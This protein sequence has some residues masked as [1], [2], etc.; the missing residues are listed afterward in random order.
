MKRRAFVTTLFSSA[1]LIGAGNKLTTLN[2]S[3]KSPAAVRFRF[4]VASDGHYGQPDTTFDEYHDEMMNWLNLEH[5]KKPLAFTMFNGDLIHDEP[6]LLPRVKTKYDQ[7]SMPYYTSH[8]NHDRVDESVWRNTWST[9]FNYSF[10]KDDLAFV[11]LNTA[12]I[13]GKYICPDVRWAKKELRKYRD[14]KAIFVFMHISPVR[15][16]ENGLNCSSLTSL[17]AK[18]KNLKAIFHGH[19]HD[20]DAM[21]PNRGKPHFFDSH[22]GG[23]WGTDYRGYRVVEVLDNGDILTYQINPASRVTVNENKLEMLQT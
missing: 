6:S 18:T 2:T 21:K 16:T 7:L 14:A 11:V 10:T 4:A 13:K 12:D 19:D 20:L 3:F 8:G 23:S 22:I 17:F 5:E 15:W 1:F 9:N